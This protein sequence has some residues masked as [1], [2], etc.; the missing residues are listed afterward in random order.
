MTNKGTVFDIMTKISIAVVF[1]WIVAFVLM[2]IF[3]CGIHVDTNWGDGAQ[4]LAFC[5]AIGCTSGEGLA[6][7]DLILDIFLI[8][9]PIPSVSPTS[10]KVP[11]PFDSI[12]N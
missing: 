2:T 6:G 12:L 11:L 9:L 5:Q 7:S 10:W 4:Q 1:L 8:L 3:D